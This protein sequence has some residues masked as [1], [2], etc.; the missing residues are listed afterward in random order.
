MRKIRTLIAGL[1]LCFSLSGCSQ[2]SNIS[3]DSVSFNSTPSDI[4]GG[5]HSRVVGAY[6]F[7]SFDDYL[8]FYNVF[9]NYNDERY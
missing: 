7:K 4:D 6:I 9:K 3:S 8:T 2:T 5:P 1:L